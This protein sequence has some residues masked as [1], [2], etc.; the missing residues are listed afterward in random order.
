MNRYLSLMAFI[1]ILMISLVGSDTWAAEDRVEN[2]T[3]Q[4]KFSMLDDGFRM[5]ID[6]VT[7]DEVV[8]CTWDGVSIFDMLS[9]QIQNGS[10]TYR[11][12]D[13]SIVLDI[14]LNEHHNGIFDDAPIFAF[15]FSDGEILSSPVV[16]PEEKSNLRWGWLRWVW[17]GGRWVLTRVGA[18][19]ASTL[20]ISTVVFGHGARHL[21]K[22]LSKSAVEK[23]IKK[24]MK[25][26]LKKGTLDETPIRGKYPNTWVKGDKR[27]NIEYKPYHLGNGKWNVGTYYPK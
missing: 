21:P 15:I 20:R 24:D 16:F 18:I 1:G 23:A 27:Y 26:R 19:G 7:V 3:P 22:G 14:P 4:I 12:V 2:V 8:D 11:T 25:N 6:N 13:G 17:Q 5:S 10:V 9:E